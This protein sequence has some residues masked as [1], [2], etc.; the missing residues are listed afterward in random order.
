MRGKK[1]A[2]SRRSSS[3]LQTPVDFRRTKGILFLKVE[4]PIYILFAYGLF[5]DAAS[6][7]DGIVSDDRTISE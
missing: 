5:H 4:F 2:W 3:I 7:S 6:S 1:S